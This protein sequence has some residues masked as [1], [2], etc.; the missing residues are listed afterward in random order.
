MIDALF[1]LVVLMFLV[2]VLLILSYV[3]LEPCAVA[4]RVF[5]PASESMPDELSSGGVSN[6]SVFIHI[7]I[8]KV[9]TYFTYG[10]NGI[11]DGS[12]S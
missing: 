2:V 9:F 10:S 4:L 1:R 5:I 8:W 3:V 11:N 12:S 6:L 7:M